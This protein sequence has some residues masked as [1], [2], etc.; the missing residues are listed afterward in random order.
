MGTHKFD[1]ILRDAELFDGL[2][3]PARRGDLAARDGRIVAIGEVGALGGSA[4]EDIDT[5][6]RALAPG[7]IDIHT[8]DDFA[9]L[10]HPDMAFKTLG[11]VTTCVVGNCGF[12]PAPYASAQAL[13][14]GLTPGSAL[15]DYGDHAGY[16]RLLEARPPA[17]NIGVLAGHGTLRHAAMGFA[18]RPPSAP[19]M[20]RMRDVLARALEA[21][22]LGLSSGLIYEPGMHAATE[23][24]I[25]LAAVM[26][27]SGA[28]YATHL[29]NEAGGLL[30]SVDEALAIGAGAGLPVLLSHHKAAGRDNWGRVRDSLARIAQA[31]ARG[32]TV[33]LDQY[34]YTAGSTM[35]AA[36][37]ANG[38]FTPTAAQGGIGDV[39]A[40]DVLVAAAPGRAEWDGRSIA[41]LAR[42]FGLAPRAAAERVV[43]EAPGAT[44]IIHMMSED[45][46]RTVLRQ[47][48]T[49]IGSDGI[50]TLDGKPHPRLYGS[51]ARVL[52]HYA[53]DLAVLDLADAVA[54]MTGL[55][56]R[57][58]GLSDRG[59]LREGAWADLTLF[60]PATVR[61][62]GTFDCPQRPPVGIVG[63][64][65]N[66][67]RVVTDGKATSERPGRVLRRV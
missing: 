22:V 5:A 53:R 46:V 10:R 38:V 27:D 28:F 42:D 41:E 24:L 23:E 61:D 63:V 14:A 43:A 47:P 59:V 20:Q 55:S 25:E 2:G 9:C 39:G 15:P 51:F 11:G 1:L 7:F 4:A 44:A 37:L 57:C 58:L 54:R 60:D 67:R 64:W 26:R 33:D 45:D 29:R 50:P 49:L 35:L 32:Q 31:R 48:G 21:G 6:G 19:E 3:G 30:D 65:V 17:V 66:G 36:V 18:A 56:A 8:H 62:V 12:G 40:E 52:G 16:A 34:P 13:F